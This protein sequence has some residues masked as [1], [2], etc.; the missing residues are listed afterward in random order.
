MMLRVKYLLILFFLLGKMTD[1]RAQSE[2]EDVPV[3]MRDKATFLSAFYGVSNY[4]GDLGGNSGKGKPYLRDHNL[5]KRTSFA[6]FSISRVFQQKWGFR[7]GYTGGRLAGSD[8]DTEFRSLDD[9]AYYR[10]K[11]NLDF[12]TSIAEWSILAEVYPLRWLPKRF[13]MHQTIVKPYFLLGI[14]RYRFNPQGSY[15][16]EIADD[17]VWVD[18]QPLRTE[19][20]G[21][22]EYPF[23][24][25]YKLTQV[26]VP[27][28]FGLSCMLGDKMSM[29]LE[30]VARKLFTDYL[31]DVSMSFVDPEVFSKYFNAE[32]AEIARA[33]HNKSSLVDPNKPYVAGEQRGNPNRNDFYHSLN[34]RIS[35][36]I[37]KQKT[38][39]VPSS[40]ELRSLPETSVP[41]SPSK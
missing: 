32:D 8:Q 18:L 31:D 29:S 2:T 41:L 5:K 26:N 38:R 9:D 20:Q 12:R 10:Y 21:M 35:I 22:A 27:Y 25:P 40:S 28:G 17:D 7:I 36:Q 4:M 30:Y 1:V 14:G 34:L 19:G 33:L 16:D 24:E 37:N 6:G 39:K 3:K 11:R 15:Y 13:G 23:H